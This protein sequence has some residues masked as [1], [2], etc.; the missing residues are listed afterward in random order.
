M[1][2]RVVRLQ[3][4]PEKV[5]DFKNLFNNTYERIRNFEGCR[6]L[7]LYNEGIDTSVFYTISKWDQP[8]QLELYR[9]SALFKQT[10]AITKTYFAGPPQA[11]SLHKEVDDPINPF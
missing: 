2:V 1:I 5:N 10:W 9:N 8:D 4:V 11:F 7:E 3:L 6:F